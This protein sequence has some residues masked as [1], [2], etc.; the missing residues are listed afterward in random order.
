MTDVALALLFV[1]GLVLLTGGA[2]ILIRGAAALA[3]RMAVPPVVVGLTVVAFGT[4]AP[5]MAVTIDAS[6]SGLGGLSVGNVIGSNVFNV[7]AILGL[8]ALVAPMVVSA[9]L[10][11]FDVPV[12]IAGSL[13]LVL[14]VL[15]GRIGRGEGLLLLSLGIGYMGLLLSRRSG[16]GRDESD[17]LPGAPGR[18]GEGKTGVLLEL[19]MV[20]GGLVLLVAGSRAVVGTSIVFA[21]AIGVSELFIGLTLVAAGTSLPELVTSLLA[22]LRGQRELAVGNVIGSN[23]TNLFLVLGPAAAVSAGGLTLPVE[24]RFFDLPVMVAA[25]VACLPIFFSGHRISR[26]EGAVFFG[27]YVAYVGILTLN[28][29]GDSPEAMLRTAL[30]SFV[31]PLGLLTLGVVGVRELIGRRRR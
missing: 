18:T 15:D 7:L 29:A 17:S 13:L 24:A 1:L 30:L 21:R 5:E 9:R 3:G 14:L 27:F 8:S 2:E 11:R 20:A 31:I 12:V 25:A 26:W 28:L 4:S 6:L 10:I 19:G 23:V 16:A 22:A